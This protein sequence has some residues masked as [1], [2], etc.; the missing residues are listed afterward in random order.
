[1]EVIMSDPK[2][3]IGTEGMGSESYSKYDPTNAPVTKHGGN[4]AIHDG[5]VT[6]GGEGGKVDDLS[7]GF[8]K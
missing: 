5:V 6:E 1:M 3:D 7:E 2:N 8:G 4:E